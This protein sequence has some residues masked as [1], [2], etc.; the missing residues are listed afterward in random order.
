MHDMAP[1][2]TRWLGGALTSQRFS[3]GSNITDSRHVSCCAPS[4][5]LQDSPAHRDVFFCRDHPARRSH[6]AKGPRTPASR[7]NPR[8]GVS[9]CAASAHHP[10][11]ASSRRRCTQQAAQATSTP[12]L[13]QPQPRRSWPPLRPPWG[14]QP[15]KHPLGGRHCLQSCIVPAGIRSAFCIDVQSCHI[16]AN[17][18][19]FN[20]GLDIRAKTLIALGY[21]SYLIPST[22]SLPFASLPALTGAAALARCSSAAGSFE[23]AALSVFISRCSSCAVNL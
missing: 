23:T 18:Y 10:E 8:S 5:E 16:A 1:I 11:Q 6:P 7:R 9:G 2:L 15:W 21:H 22:A 4:H 12:A 17:S 13:T 3:P 19:T 14:R 20:D